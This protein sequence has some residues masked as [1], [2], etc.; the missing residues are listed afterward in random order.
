M[1]FFKL[2]VI[3]IKNFFKELKT[4]DDYVQLSGA[5]FSQG[6]KSIFG[7][8]DSYWADSASDAI[9][10]MMIL[11]GQVKNARFGDF[12]K[13]YN[14]LRVSYEKMPLSNLD[15]NF[16]ELQKTHPGSIAPKLWSTLTSNAPK[17]SACI[18]YDE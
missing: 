3:L 11:C 15:G 6:S 2:I 17:T 5:L 9:A 16:K 12:L 8:L 1:L 14:S 4:E 7:E 10:A 13:L 18:F